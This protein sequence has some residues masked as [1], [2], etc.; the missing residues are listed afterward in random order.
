MASADVGGE[1]GSGEL[2]AE[3]ARAMQSNYGANVYKIAMVSPPGQLSCYVLTCNSQHRLCEVLSSVQGIV[4][5]L[6]VVDSGSMDQ[7]RDIA[8]RHGARFLY[9]SFD[10]FKRQRAFALAQCTHSWV[11]ELDSD[12]V[13]SDALRRRLTLLAANNFCEGGKSPDA[14]GIKRKWFLLGREIHCFYPSVCPDRPVKLFKKDRITYETGRGIHEG[15][16]GFELAKYID[17]PILHYTCDTIEQMYG[18][19]NL[20]TTLAAKEMHQGGEKASLVKLV[21]YPWILWF[22]WYIVKGGCK[23]G[24]L[25][26][27]HGRYV[28]DT[29]YQKYLKLRLDFE[30]R[31]TSS[32]RPAV[33]EKVGC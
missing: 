13:V 16:S 15:K 29:V 23:D 1:L 8:E 22:W 18:K 3:K 25:G 4:D 11:L 19:I 2:Y 33:K 31:V 5:D 6:L 26:L 17:E 14:F 21:V 7:T 9:R 24:L 10:D 27:V 12:E 32:E 20:Y 30:H 28:R